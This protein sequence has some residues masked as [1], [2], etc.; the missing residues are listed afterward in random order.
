[1]V[2]L[3]STCD[4]N[5]RVIGRADDV[6]SFVA[7]MH[8]WFRISFENVTSKEVLQDGRIKLSVKGCCE[9]SFRSS[10]ERV[11][12]P[13][14]VAS[15]ELGLFIEVFAENRNHSVTEHYAVDCGDVV[16]YSIA[17]CIAPNYVYC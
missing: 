16:E 14:R 9:H 4:F 15:E 8:K 11:R 17:R 10:M 7:S 3:Q 5:L 12:Y 13:I 2:F 6:F 1:M